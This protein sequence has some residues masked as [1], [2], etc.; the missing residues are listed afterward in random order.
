ML[1]LP[2]I[3]ESSPYKQKHQPDAELVQAFQRFREAGVLVLLQE[4]VI[5]HPNQFPGLEGNFHF[6]FDIFTPGVHQ[7]IKAV[8]LLLQ[9]GQ[10]EDF[11]LVVGPVHVV[12]PK[13]LEIADH[14]PTGLLGRRKVAAIPP[15]LLVEGQEGT[16]GLLVAFTQINILALLL[17]KNTGCGKVGVNEFCC[18][19]ARLNVVNA[20]K[21]TRNFQDRVG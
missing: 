20:T 14:D 13:R 1:R 2:K 7:K 5:E 17:N 6:P 15:R 4:R 3:P 9:V 21:L 18:D 11:R 19:L 16:V 10:L 12:D 8:V